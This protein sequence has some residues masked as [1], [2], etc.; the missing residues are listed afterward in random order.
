MVKIFIFVLSML[1]TSYGFAN[2]QHEYDSDTA[3][4]I[5]SIYWLTKTEDSAIVYS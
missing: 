2:A 3:E 1:F 4:Y 5:Q